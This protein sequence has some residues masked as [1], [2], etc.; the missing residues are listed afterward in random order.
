MI[1]RELCLG[2]GSGILLGLAP[3]LCVGQSFII[4]FGGLSD[5]TFGQTNP[6]YLEYGV[7]ANDGTTDIY[8]RIESKDFITPKN[9]SNNGSVSGDAR[10]NIGPDGVGDAVRFELALFENSGYTT[11]YNPGAFYEW[12]LMFYDIDGQANGS[13]WDNISFHTEGTYTVT[14]STALEITH[15]GVSSHFSGRYI[16]G[17]NV[18]TQGGATT[19]GNQSEADAAVLYKVSNRNSL[20]FTYEASGNGRNTLID[21]GEVNFDGFGTTVTGVVGIGVPEPGSLALLF[22]GAP[23]VF[24]R[25][26][27][28]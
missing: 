16:D 5:V 11:P 22:L 23:I 24:G 7:V 15:D 3:V 12:Q 27:Q 1:I 25:R 17:N 26:R 6:D 14:G 2:K 10:I 18:R 13:A 8:A 20:E 19:F 9:A 21:G 4:D 28:R